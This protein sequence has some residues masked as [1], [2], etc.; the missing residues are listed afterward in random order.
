VTG[1][2]AYLAPHLLERRDRARA[3]VESFVGLSLDEARQLAEKIDVPLKVI[4]P[5]AVT[6]AEYQFGRI[7]ISL[8]SHDRVTQ[9]VV[10]G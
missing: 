3:H 9:A 8:D 6:S 10:S 5:G 4:R 2:E 7:R 1:P